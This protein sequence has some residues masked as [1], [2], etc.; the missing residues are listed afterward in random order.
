MRPSKL[1]VKV[2]CVTE[3]ASNCLQVWWLQM[4]TFINV[5]CQMIDLLQ[6]RASNE[7]EKGIDLLW[8]YFAKSDQGNLHT[9]VTSTLKHDLSITLHLRSYLIKAKPILHIYLSTSKLRKNICKLSLCTVSPR[10]N[11]I[12]LPSKSQSL[13]DLLRVVC[14]TTNSGTSRCRAFSRDGMR[15]TLK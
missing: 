13:A 1:K 12:A 10:Q 11:L 3:S 2:T 8:K 5:K 7:K 15:N 6:F 9:K 4:I 14:T